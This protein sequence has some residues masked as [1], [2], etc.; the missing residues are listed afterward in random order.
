M[1]EEEG[2][3]LLNFLLSSLHQ[4]TDGT[5]IKSH[6]RMALENAC[7]KHCAVSVLL[8]LNGPHLF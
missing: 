8:S 7:L 6:T 4:R 1:V 3:S 2:D 5:T